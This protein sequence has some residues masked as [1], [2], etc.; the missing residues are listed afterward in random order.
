MRER[1]GRKVRIDLNRTDLT[2]IRPGLDLALKRQQAALNEQGLQ[3]RRGY[4]KGFAKMLRD[5]QGALAGNNAGEFYFDVT[6]ISALT[7]ALSET[8]RKRLQDKTARSRIQKRPL[9]QKFEM[10]AEKLEKIRKC[11][12]REDIKRSGKAAYDK[13]RQR[14][15]AFKGWLHDA[16]RAA[17]Q[18]DEQRSGPE[19][20]TQAA[21]TQPDSATI[22]S[23]RLWWQS[24]QDLLRELIAERTTIQVSESKL[25]NLVSRLRA[26]MRRSDDDISPDDAVENPEKAKNYA[27]DYLKERRD[28]KGKI[29]LGFD[30]MDFS[31]ESSA[32]ADKLRSATVVKLPEDDIAETDAPAEIR[33][34]T[35]DTSK[36]KRFLKGAVASGAH[37][38]TSAIKS[39]T[40]DR[41]HQAVLH[42]PSRHPTPSPQGSAART[43]IPAPS[44]T[45]PSRIHIKPISESD[46]FP[47]TAPEASPHSALPQESC[48]QAMVLPEHTKSPP[49]PEKT[50]AGG[51]RNVPQPFDSDFNSEK[52]PPTKSLPAVTSPESGT[53]HEQQGSF[54]KVPH[55]LITAAIAAWL[56]VEVK[57]PADCWHYVIDE[58]KQIAK[59]LPLF[60]EQKPVK[61][62]LTFQ[63]VLADNR[64]ANG[65]GLIPGQTNYFSSWIVNSL[66]VVCKTSNQ[67]VGSLESGLQKAK[68]RRLE[69]EIRGYNNPIRYI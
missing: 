42:Q 12:E 62:E 8:R 27:F 68:A 28:F 32:R 3:P 64:P 29:K 49:V 57:G 67:I 30:W 5:L 7:F 11:A 31:T 19:P 14:W 56:E 35:P 33:N 17:N 66:M 54:K 61:R 53:A 1:K 60:F 37:T 59:S 52:S 2:L 38:S 44:T 50:A 6:Q 39:P 10:A 4:D 18:K 41:Q 65:S 55:E 47:K 58:A 40:G 22:G 15:K 63:Q 13:R 23:Q 26:Q 25:P 69:R 16:I 46:A 9:I 43:S 51:A 36:E 20:L 45:F 21:N 48:E 34:G 24:W